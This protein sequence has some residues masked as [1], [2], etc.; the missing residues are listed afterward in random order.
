[1]KALPLAIL[2][3]V[4]IAG[5]NSS[6]DTSNTP[7]KLKIALITPGPTNDSGWNAMAL[8][9]LNAIKD[10]MGA[11]VSQE[12]ASGE[13]K[14]KDSMKSYAQKGYDLIFGHGYEYNAPAAE[15]GPD[16]P[17]TVFVTSSG[18]KTGPN[19][20]AFR[21]ELEQGF[22]LAGIVAGKMDKTNTV[23]MIGG[24]DVPS[25]RSTFDAFAAGAKSVKPGI[26]VKEVFTGNGTD[27]AAAKTATLQAISQG[28]D[29]VIHQANNAAS[30]VFEACKEKNVYAFGAN[31]DQNSDPSGIILGSAVIVAKPA[32][33]ALAKEVAAGTYKGSV[34]SFGMDS[35]AID[36]VFNPALTSKVPADVQK[37]VTDTEAKIKSGDVKVPERKF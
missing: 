24:D 33:L 37:L 31:A 7:K 20:G 11:D 30:G 35:G 19:V 28:A 16:F 2:T 21:F 13:Q 27:P 1:M 8:D 29:F 22:Y 26:T 34:R 3:L 9:G 25:I 14:I 23:A 10:S 32:F 15:L 4:A 6:S 17:K 5:C 18:D 12:E 36:F